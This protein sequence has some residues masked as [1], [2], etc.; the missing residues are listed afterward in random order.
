MKKVS[1]ED[2]MNMY[3]TLAL[4]KEELLTKKYSLYDKK[5][6]NKE[7]KALLKDLNK[8]SKEHIKLIIELMSNLNIQMS[9]RVI[10]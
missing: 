6:K 7:V 8:V 3:F 5:T 2:V 4:N 1:Q 9:G 10:K